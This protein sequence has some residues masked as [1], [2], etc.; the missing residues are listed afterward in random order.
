MSEVMQEDLWRGRFGDAYTERNRPRLADSKA[1]F[2]KVLGGRAEYIESCIE[3]GANRGHN[4]VALRKLVADNAKLD[5][6]E[7]N[8]AAFSE[9]E[10]VADYAYWMS[11]LDFVA[12]PDWT[13]VLTKGLLIHIPPH[14]LQHA[15]SI[16]YDSSKR[17]IL[18]CEYF[19]PVPVVVR[20]RGQDAALWK[21]DF[22]SDML[23]LYP[24]LKVVDYGWHWSRDPHPQ[25]DITWWLLEK[26]E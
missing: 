2:K 13:L 6:V 3:F 10:T 9:L 8:E 4:L 24:T 14:A 5:G 1:F 16:L 15:Y 21:R 23:D 18:M 26:T 19:N 22:G 20:Y 11:M 12:R 17:W 25:D 7:I